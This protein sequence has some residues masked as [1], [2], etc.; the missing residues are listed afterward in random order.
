MDKK[1]ILCVDDNVSFNSL[2]RMTLEGKEFDVKMATTPE[3]AKECVGKYTFDLILLDLN[4]PSP[5]D[6]M[7]TLEW[8]VNNR[9]EI[10]V[11]MISGDA[12]ISGA[13]EALKI[14]AYD[15]IEKPLDESRLVV[16]VRNT[17]SRNELEYRYAKA[18][19]GMIG[20]STIMKQ[21]FARI[22]RIARSDEPV[23]IN[24]E[25]GTGKELVA[26]GIHNLSRRMD[27]ELVSVNCAS[28]PKDLIDSELFGHVKGAFTGA[29]RERKGYFEYA[30]QSTI[31][32]D[33]VGDMPPEI[34]VKILRVLD[35]HEIRRIGSNKNID[36][37][38]R[39][40][41]ATNKDLQEEIKN[42]NFRM[43]LFYRLSGLTIQ[44]PS[45]KER[46]EDIPSL[47][48][49]FLYQAC[50]KNK[51]PLKEISSDVISLLMHH[52]WPGNV[53]ELQ[54]AVNSAVVFCDG[55]TITP[56]DL[57]LLTELQPI[58]EDLTLKEATLNFQRDYIIKNLAVH[59]W[60]VASTAKVLG[61]DRTNL[62]KKMKKFKIP[63]KEKMERE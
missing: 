60:N 21:V 10:P 25:T 51:I 41:A 26:K 8:L 56:D 35:N 22:K 30:N 50:H 16:T 36:I 49:H 20:N 63:T 17:I 29:S 44:L 39:I 48:D 53:R 3:E 15:F 23:L 57:E 2:L 14:G 6:G 55:D 58:P 28:I 33:E 45:L 5:E 54:K 52:D 62:F 42:G 24:G 4:L 47:A 7:K 27:K 12:K 18:E 59:S 46:R 34:Q 37:D 40:I 31:F 9:P 43:D 19:T 13:V 61:I 11:I 1:S 38:V 32:L